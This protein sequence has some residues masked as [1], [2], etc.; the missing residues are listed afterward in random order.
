MGK[1]EEHRKEYKRKSKRL[2]EGL[3][4]YIFKEIVGKNRAIMQR[5]SKHVGQ[6]KKCGK[7]YGRN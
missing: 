2:A 4:Q 6:Q 1:G 5:I 3:S 7:Y